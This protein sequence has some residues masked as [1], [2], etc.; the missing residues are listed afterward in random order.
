[1]PSSWRPTVT[2][3]GCSASSTS[4]PQPMR[5]QVVVTELL[6]EQLYGRPHYARRGFD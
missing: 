2:R 6:V 4:S 5:G 3:V 1:M